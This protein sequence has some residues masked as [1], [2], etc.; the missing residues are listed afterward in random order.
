MAKKTDY[1]AMKEKL[2]E[3]LTS[4]TTSNEDGRKEFKY[5][6]QLTNIAHREQSSIVVELDDVADFDSDLAEA[7]RSNTRRFIIVSFILP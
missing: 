5:A 1:D 6:Q 7:I 3:F 4:Y 2:K